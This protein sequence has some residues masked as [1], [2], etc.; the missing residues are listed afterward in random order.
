MKYYIIIFLLLIN[1]AGKT[2]TSGF[3]VD[4]GNDTVFCPKLYPDTL[5]HIGENVKIIGGI[6]P[7]TYQWGCKVMYN[8]YVAYATYFL[9]DTN[10]LNPYIKT[11]LDKGVY[12][13]LSVKDKNSNI[14]IDSIFINAT[15]F[16][17]NLT[18]YDFN[19][20][21][22]DSLQFY[23]NHFVGGGFPPVK[24]FWSPSTGLEDSAKIDTWCKPQ[25]STE[26][27]QYIIDSAGCKSSLN[28]VYN[29]NFLPTSINTSTD[30]GSQLNLHQIGSC[31]FFNNPQNTIARISF[32]SID[33]KKILTTK[34]NNSFYDIAY[35]LGK[36]SIN[37][38]VV[39][40]DRIKGTL[41]IY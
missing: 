8:T 1:F 33:G 34:T 22:G 2:Q 20:H 6:A 35:L 38:C 41:K 13:K 15:K 24:Y 5:F 17:Y 30:K 23:Y 12:F 14:A 37:I 10:V 32:Y 39:T 3:K 25:K 31:L 16:I 36:N 7:F 29:I 26:Y 27:Y 9:N 40:I 19:M 28:R 21:V 11:I 18:E 4:C